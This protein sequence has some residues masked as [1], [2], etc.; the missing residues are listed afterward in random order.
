[1][2]KG[3]LYVVSTPIG[4]LEDI[5]FRAVRVL[6]EVDLIAAEDT[7]R[8][9]KLLS[10]YQIRAPLV[11]YHTFNS[12][13]R[14]PRI[15][16][17]LREG[18]TVAIVTDA[19]TPALSDPGAYLVQ[20]VAREGI[21]VEPVPGPSAVATLLSIAG[22]NA[23]TSHFYGFPP[24]RKSERRRS[25]EDIRYEEDTLVFFESPKRL[26]GLLSDL[27]EIFGDREAI[28]GRELTKVHEEH[29]RGSL[30]E[31]E[32]KYRGQA[33]PGE[34]TLAVE[35]YAEAEDP[36]EM[37]E[38]EGDIRRLK[39]AGLKKEEILEVLSAW[40]KVPKRMVYRELVRLF[41]G[42]GAQ[43]GKSESE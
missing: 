5:T 36:Q 38:L 11:S 4:N 43:K 7:R 15:L 37:P 33:P 21:P 14:V 24:A 19:G 23:D 25:L 26:A 35:G 27:V 32:K 13:V 31:L 1:M 16:S 8:T 22:M 41:P 2:K 10:H 42:K 6:R 17:A 30:R 29:M 9:R 3:R 40:R 18:K 39:E 28:I 34:V 12:R 20:E